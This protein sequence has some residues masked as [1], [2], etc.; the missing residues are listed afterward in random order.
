MNT[1]KL[2]DFPKIH[3][4]F[5]RKLF[6]VNVEQWKKYGSEFQLRRPKVYLVVDQINPGYEWVF[7]DPDTFAVEKLNG[8]NVKILIKDGRLEKIQ[9]RKNIID[10]LQVLKGKTFI[11]EGIFKSIQKGYIRS[12]NEHSGELIGP[13]FQGNPYNLDFHEFYPFDRAIKHLRYKSFHNY[14]RT[15]D[16]WSLWFKDYLFSLLVMSRTNKNDLKINSEGVI[17]Y[18]LKRKNEGKVYMAKLRRD[19]FKWYYQDKIEV[20]NYSK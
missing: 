2:I 6:N 15:F 13:K 12:D 3:C 20:Y 19:M 16:N 5:I 1:E 4:P 14:E 7:N 11:I 9:N 18:N 10:P 8:S 17:F